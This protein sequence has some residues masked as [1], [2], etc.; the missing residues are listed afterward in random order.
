MWQGVI[1]DQVRC[2]AKGLCTC[3]CNGQTRISDRTNAR[4]ARKQRGAAVEQVDVAVGFET[5][6]LKDI[7]GFLA[8]GMNPANARL[9]L[10]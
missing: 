10:G 1:A 2:L 8:I 6:T 9:G 7:E 4:G 5:F 3:P